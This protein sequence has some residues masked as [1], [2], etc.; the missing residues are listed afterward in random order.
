M[1]FCFITPFSF[2][3]FFFF[4]FFIFPQCTAS[5]H[6]LYCFTLLHSAAS[7]IIPRRCFVSVLH[8]F[9]RSAFCFIRAPRSFYCFTLMFCLVSVSL[10]QPTV[11]L[12]FWCFVLCI[13]ASLTFIGML[14]YCGFYYII[15]SPS[16]LF[17]LYYI[18]FSHF[19]LR[20]SV[21]YL[22]SSFHPL[23]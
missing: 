4:T 20:C 22:I 5:V 12:F 21:S 6:L 19:N 15:T 7:L 1:A 3:F 23:F 2:F 17:F 10:S 16:V 13:V 14:L 11:S 8:G 9:T 18:A